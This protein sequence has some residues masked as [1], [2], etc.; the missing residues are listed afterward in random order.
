MDEEQTRVASE[1]VQRLAGWSRLGKLVWV[2]VPPLSGVVRQK[3]LE[4]SSCDGLVSVV[5]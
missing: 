5:L 4:F 1:G 3:G 2:W